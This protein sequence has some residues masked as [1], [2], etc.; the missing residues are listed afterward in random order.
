M[1]NGIAHTH[2]NTIVV[3][4]KNTTIITAEYVERPSLDR[5]V[6]PAIRIMIRQET[7]MDLG[8]AMYFI[9]IQDDTL[10]NVRMSLFEIHYK[11]V[12]DF[13]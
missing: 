3:K 13:V 7:V 4:W 1:A 5:D 11:I 6:Q 2:Q 8:C 9:C 12:V 10:S